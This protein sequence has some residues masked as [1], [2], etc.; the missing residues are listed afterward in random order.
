MNKNDHIP[1]S[2]LR[3]YYANFAQ[4][5]LNTLYKYTKQPQRP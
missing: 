3:A 2:L 5:T 4:G 1:Y